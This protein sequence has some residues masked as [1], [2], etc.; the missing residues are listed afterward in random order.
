MWHGGYGQQVRARALSSL[1]AAVSVTACLS[2]PATPVQAAKHKHKP[3]SSTVIKLDMQELGLAEL[4]S[5]QTSAEQARVQLRKLHAD[6]RAAQRQFPTLA[7]RVRTSRALAAEARAKYERR[8]VR[9]DKLTDHLNELT[10]RYMDMTGA[11]AYSDA[12]QT[13]QV[14]DL[15]QMAAESASVQDAVLVNAQGELMMSQMAAQL[16][17]I[18]LLAEDAAGAR[19]QALRGKLAAESAET[20]A[21]QALNEQRELR[22]VLADTEKTTKRQLAQDRR[23]LSTLLDRL[24]SVDLPLP[25]MA[26]GLDDLDA[27]QRIA[28]LARREYD[29]GVAE[30]P[31]GSNESPDIARYRSATVGAM[32]GQP[33][34]AYFASY[35][36]RRAGV[37]IGDGGV[38][39]GYVPY[40]RSW[41]ERVDRFFTGTKIQ[42]QAGDL[43]LWPQHIGVVISADGDN[44]I[45]IEGNS[46]DR[47]SRRERLA[48]E[49]AG[50]VRLG[51]E[52]LTD[53][54][55]QGNP[56]A[57]T[58]DDTL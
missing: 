36:A 7:R 3:A 14:A 23:R 38:G 45:T 53:Q 19:E 54:D 9:A 20:A 40:V 4:E 13:G 47:V 52:P 2:L 27:A 21:A 6:R 49:A 56:E 58:P 29:R 35:I 57:R 43:I 51:G 18:R 30:E 10:L 37:P 17:E 34:C 16:E 11:A 22:T 33:W 26:K 39:Q 31:L 15:A 55:R 48:S 1:L 25:D 44:L 28:L 32:G 24:L 12:A 41:A 42:P 8:T 5:R 50:F 46:S